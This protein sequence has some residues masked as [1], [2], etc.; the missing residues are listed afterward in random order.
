M[1][2][3]ISAATQAVGRLPAPMAVAVG[4]AA[5]IAVVLPGSWSLLNHFGRLA[6]EGAHA[7][8][9]SCL[10]GRVVGVHLNRKERNGQ[11]DLLTTGGSFTTTVVG[12]FGPSGFGLA[13]AGLIAHDQ[14]VPV[15]WIGVALLAILLLSMRGVFGIAL[16]VGVGWLLLSIARS[17]NAGLEAVT[18]YGLSW[19]LLISGI[20]GVLDRRDTGSGDGTTMR[21]IT[22]LPQGLWYYFWLVGSVAALIWGASMLV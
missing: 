22:G 6:H 17:K 3:V 14:I 4:V 16:V 1:A 10:G 8:V 13:A 12:Y 5:A 20:R 21:E 18:A 9:G 19:L 11:T 15:L 7:V 2:V